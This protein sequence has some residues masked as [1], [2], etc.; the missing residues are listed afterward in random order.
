M[1]TQDLH[2]L[3]ILKWVPHFVAENDEM[4]HCNMVTLFQWSVPG[5][6]RP[7]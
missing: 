3:C 4:H 5:R 1:G 2:D 7:L 6:Q